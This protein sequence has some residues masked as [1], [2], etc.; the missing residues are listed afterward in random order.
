M[1]HLS[2]KRK[3][4]IMIA[5][6]AAMFFAAINQTIVSTAMPRIIAILGGMDYYTWVITIYMLTSTI[7]TVLVGKLSDIYGRKPFILAGIVFFIIG[8]FLSGFARDIFDLIT[9]RGIQGVGAGIIMSCAFTAVGDL[10]PPRERGKWTGVMMAVF[11]FSSVLGPTLGGWI[12]DHM[13]WKWVFWIFLP[14]GIIAFVLIMILF[15]KVERRASEKIDYAGSLFLTLTIVP[16]LLGFSWAGTKYDWGSQQILGL[17][18]AAL[19]SL[20]IFIWVESKAKSP[21]LPLSLFRNGIITISNVIGF[22]MN[23]GMMGALI[24]LS[25]FVQGVLGI[26]PTYSGYVTMPMS[27]SMVVVSAVT[28]RLI[29]KTGKYKRYALIGMPVMV[30]S[31]VMMAYMNSV[32]MAVLSM[33]IFGFGLG[34]GMPVF[35]L[36]VQNAAKPSELGVATASSQL[37][38][39]LG[40]TIGIAVMGTIMSSRLVSNLK[41][42]LAS[43][44]GVDISKLDPAVASK[45]AAFQN[46]EM[47]LDQ[48]RLAELQRTLPAEIQPVLAKMIDMLRDALSSSLTTV[49]LAGA[50][51]LVVA[52]VLTFF[53]K[54]IPLRTSNKMN[55]EPE[56]S[57]EDGKLATS[58]SQV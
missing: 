25:F 1:E 40:G 14:I 26:A 52:M 53:L 30:L 7:A 54:E 23:A 50:A 28:G 11:G 46:P 29:T 15:P 58:T 39:N 10:F 22:L 2:H 3:L 17:F 45:L 42:T 35:S 32:W 36:T 51:L 5:I 20:I 31:M 34:L 33:L 56:K 4:T 47:L 16:L 49:F 21:V 18:G 12:V 44:G 13:S 24:Y 37:F 48:P 6:I 57:K 8:A 38:R 41:A 55:D 27:L 9:Y 43:G 19:V